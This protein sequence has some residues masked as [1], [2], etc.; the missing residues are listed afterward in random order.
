MRAV[1]SIGE[2][3]VVV[4]IGLAAYIGARQRQ[5]PAIERAFIYAGMAYALN[6]L[7]KLL[8]HRKRPHGRIIRTLGIQSYSFPSGH[9]FGTVLLYGLL[10]YLAFRHLNGP[11]ESILSCLLVA[12]IFVMGL[13]RVYLGSHYP[14]DVLAGWVLGFLSLAAVIALA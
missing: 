12:L 4:S 8:L 7:L 5:H 13:S 11:V 2:P 10:A 3:L 9:A 6:I 14:S 1:S